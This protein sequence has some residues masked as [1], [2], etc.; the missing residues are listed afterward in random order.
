M[1]GATQSALVCAPVFSGLTSTDSVQAVRDS[2]RDFNAVI[3]ALVW[4]APD[5]ARTGEFL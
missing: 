4:L 2:G 1:L 3:A 5:N